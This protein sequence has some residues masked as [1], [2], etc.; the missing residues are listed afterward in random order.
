[1]R[2]AEP[3]SATSRAALRAGAPE[4]V[5]PLPEWIPAD[6]PN[7]EWARF[8]WRTAAM[9]PGAWFDERK[10]NQVV[11][12]WPKVFKLTE[13]RFAGK[14][15]RLIL[16]QEIIVRL[17]VGWKHP[18]EVLDEETFTPR[19]EH[20]RL[21]RRLM[22]WIPRKNGKSEFLAALALLFFVLEGTIGGQGFAFARDEKQGKIVFDKMKAMISMS[23]R[24]ASGIQPFKKSIWVPQIRA[25]FE[26]LTGK[27][28]GK[29]GRSPTVIAGDEMHEWKSIDL[30][31]TLR[32][33]TG[34]RLEPIELYAST[35]GIKS[36]LVGY[37]LWEETVAILERRIDD[38]TTLAVI[39][40]ADQ[41]ADWQ[42]ERNW[43]GP[44]PSLGLS[45]TIQFLRREAAIAK[46]NPRAEAHFRRYHLNQWVEAAV[47]WI[48]VRK[49]DACAAD[50]AAWKKYREALKGRRGFGAVDVSS[51]Q[52]VTTEQIVFPPTDDDPKWRV[53]SRFWVP[54]DSLEIRV[55]NDRVPYDRFHKDGALETTPGDF[56]DQNYVLRAMLQS[57]EDF[58]IAGWALDPWNTRKLNADL[59]REGID[60]EKLHDFRQGIHSFAGPSRD[61]ERLV[62]AGLFDH[63]G[64]PVMRWM[65]QN[66]AVR[67]DENMNY[68]PA[69]KKS[70]EKIDGI[71]G[72]VMAVGLA[73]AEEPGMNLDGFLANPVIIQ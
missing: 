6:D 15:F 11:R 3:A 1:M 47:R 21:F 63:G 4:S 24:L 57:E 52:D 55:K 37:S 73:M 70:A 42:D 72:A 29:H 50:K 46:D 7:Y 18:V 41:E 34:A 10:A 69:K 17:L 48:N 49:W 27:P 23:P 64:H 12:L 35:A 58:D 39:F 31:T 14:P 25:V 53:L 13:D 38:P 33:G 71:V 44:N 9:Q 54:E 67:F 59:Q 8:A 60:V 28:E 30:A 36:A 65:A 40:A 16:W 62:Y 43:P 2:A 5:F 56:V 22:L 61:F 68:M 20:V 45:P 66:C 32:Q 26:L 51:T 19:F